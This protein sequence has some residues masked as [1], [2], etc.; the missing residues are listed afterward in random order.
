MCIEKARKPRAEHN[1][2]MGIRYY[3]YAFDGA[4]TQ[5]AIED[6]DSIVSQDP[7]ADAWGFTPGTYGIL[8]ATF[9]QALPERD[10]LNLDKAWPDLQQV[11]GPAHD[12]VL[13]RPAFRMFEGDVHWGPFG[14]D[15]W[16]RIIPP[17]EVPIIAADLEA[18]TEDD[19][20]TKLDGRPARYFDTVDES[21]EYIQ[22]AIERARTFV[23]GLVESGRGFIYLIR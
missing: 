19:I 20:R 7:L 8:D 10:F 21:V 5:Q 17:R 1:Q 22:N 3:A 9:K 11:T 14:H 18:L 13:P 23:R 6:P 2:L 4:A 12:K 15:R 16:M